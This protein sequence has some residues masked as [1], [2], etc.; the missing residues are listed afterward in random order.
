MRT[1]PIGQKAHAVKH[2][3]KLLTGST[4]D[5]Y[6]VVMDNGKTIIFISDRSKEEE[7]RLK[8]KQRFE[9]VPTK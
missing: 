9:H 4:N 5:K 3:S 8:Y 1:E 7:T 6:A 2:D